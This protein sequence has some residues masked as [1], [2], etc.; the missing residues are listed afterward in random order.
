MRGLGGITVVMTLESGLL[1]LLHIKALLGTLHRQGLCT[2]TGHRRNTMGPD[3][4]GRKAQM[5]QREE[6]EKEEEEEEEKKKDA[7]SDITPEQA[8][9]TQ[10]P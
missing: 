5:K 1:Q 3:K 2:T 8:G 7:L 10:D 6:Q 9:T 4:D